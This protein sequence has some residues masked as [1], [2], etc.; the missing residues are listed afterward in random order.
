MV[1]IRFSTFITSLFLDVSL[2][3]HFLLNLSRYFRTVPY[4][5]SVL[6]LPYLDKKTDASDYDYTTYPPLE[7][8]PRRY[9]IPRR[10][11][12]M[13]KESDVLVAYVLHDWGGAAAMLNY[14]IRRKKEIIRLEKI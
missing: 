2:L 5:V 14:A 6:V 13:V 9:A 1:F 10:N 3:Y 4:I 11:Q 12:W 8:V 7:R